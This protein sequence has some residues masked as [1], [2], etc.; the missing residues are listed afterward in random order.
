MPPGAAPA[1]DV[2]A[3]GSGGGTADPYRNRLR[4]RAERDDVDG[5][6]SGHDAALVLSDAATSAVTS[7]RCAAG[8]G[9]SCPPS[10]PASAASDGARTS[11]WCEPADRDA[12]PE[13]MSQILQ[14][15][16]KCRWKLF[17]L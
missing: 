8:E 2:P 1:H 5:S 12:S 13:N 10:D 15:F 11:A 7:S 6:S 4:R 14:P 3:S 9:A 16:E 17:S